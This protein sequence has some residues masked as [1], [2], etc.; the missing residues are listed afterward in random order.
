LAFV[1]KSQQA[2]S[3]RSNVFAASHEVLS[4]GASATADDVAMPANFKEKK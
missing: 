1:T 4:V 2:P 3:E